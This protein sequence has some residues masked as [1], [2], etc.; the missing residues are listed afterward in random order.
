M[1][2][3]F[4]LIKPSW[5]MINEPPSLAKDSNNWAYDYLK[6]D[7]I[8]KTYGMDKPLSGEGIKIAVIDS[9][10]DLSEP[11]LAH[12]LE[13]RKTLDFT[14]LT[15]G[16]KQEF[17]AM[18]ERQRIRYF[19]SSFEVQQAKEDR[20]NGHGTRMAAIIGG[21]NG[22]CPNCELAI[23][24]VYDKNELPK[25][26]A[27]AFAIYWAI[28]NR[29][30]L[31]NISQTTGGPSELLHNAV[32][33]AYQRETILLCGAGNQQNNFTAFPAAFQKTIA[34]GGYDRELTRYRNPGRMV[35]F[36]GPAED[37][38]I[39]SKGTHGTWSGTSYATAYI[40]GIMGLYL[41]KLFQVNNGDSSIDLSTIRQHMIDAS[42]TGGLEHVGHGILHPKWLF[43]NQ[44]D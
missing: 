19:E 4:D 23:I 31:V 21:K 9:G 11:E 7:E 17:L 10:C 26:E 1:K 3:G 40:T 5:P 36:I 22:I 44:F 34:I 39:N 20:D 2:S 37:V 12:Q 24:N 28:A 13:K 16:L 38:E 8:R 6:I 43:K 42:F 27:I 32:V 33:E 25:R 18:T 15:T 41:E 35:D 30:H 14:T 29:Y